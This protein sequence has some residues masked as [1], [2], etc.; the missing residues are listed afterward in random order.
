MRKS[1][2]AAMPAV[3]EIVTTRPERWAR[4]CG[5]AAR[6]TLTGPN[7]VVSICERPVLR[8]HLLEE[9]GLEAAGVVHQDVE[10]P[11]PLHGCLHS[12]LRGGGIG[13]VKSHG[14]EVVVLPEASVTLSAVAGGGD[15]GMPGG[16]GGLGDVDAQ[17]PACAGHEP[18]LLLGHLDALPSA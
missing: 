8:G 10:V 17:A 7:N 9:P 3:D 14:E 5:S 18:Y 12:G 1:P 13:D 11:E 2:S 6:V 15:H 16:Q 4:I